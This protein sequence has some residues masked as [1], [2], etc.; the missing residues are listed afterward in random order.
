MR[1]YARR[2]RWAKHN[3]RLLEDELYER[4]TLGDRQDGGT[5]SL[6][7][8]LT[9]MQVEAEAMPGLPD[10]ARPAPNAE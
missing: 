6:G 8:S 2:R 3:E 10:R 4:E 5:P 7:N 9:D 1:G